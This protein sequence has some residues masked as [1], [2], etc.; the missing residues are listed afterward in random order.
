MTEKFINFVVL[1]VATVVLSGVAVTEPSSSQDVIVGFLTLITSS[2]GALDA[3]IV[4]AVTATSGT[5]SE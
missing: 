1:A 3:E 4:V 5:A 2:G